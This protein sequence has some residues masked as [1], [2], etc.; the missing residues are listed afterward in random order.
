M[1]QG[2]KEAQTILDRLG[3]SFDL[4]YFDD[5]STQSMPDWKTTDGHYIEVTHT[6]HNNKIVAG[7]NAFSQLDTAQ[8]LSKME[9]AWAA[10]TRH[11]KKDYEKDSSGHLTPAAMRQHRQDIKLI[12]SH[13][14]MTADGKH[15]EFKCDMP[16]IEHSV[17][18]I[19][20][21][22]VTDKGSKYTDGK[23]DLFVFVTEDEYRIF[24]QLFTTK[25]WNMAYTHFVS[26]ISAAPF[27]AIYICSWDFDLQKY[28]TRNSTL[29]K[30]E[31]QDDGSIAFIPMRY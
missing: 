12:E 30:I 4:S 23:T 26:A 5:N 25:D 14:G 6:K 29:T 13:F 8:R 31:K 24:E 16:T 10:H 7:G 11:Q 20:Q 1:K 21:E 19:L 27:R 9:E 2:E 3:I 17:D 22:I 28:T 15:T 18:N